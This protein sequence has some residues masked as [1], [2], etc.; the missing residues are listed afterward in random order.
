MVKPEE[1][2]NVN[3]T[4]HFR[5]SGA[6]VLYRG[7]FV[8][9]VGPTSDGTK[10]GV[11]RL[12]GHKEKDE[13]AIVTAKREAMEEASV[14]ITPISSS[15]TFYVKEWN[16]KPIK[17]EIKEEIAPIL[18]K[19]SEETASIMYLSYSKTKPLPS[20]ETK[21][22]LFLS[23][24]DVHLVCSNKLTL[25]DFL[26]QNG[27]SIIQSVIDRDLILEPFPQLLFL[28]KLL[29]EEKELMYEYIRRQYH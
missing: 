13:S 11:V 1:G 25:N 8:F 17:L 3:I 4:K 22:L 10:L 6:Y 28:S 16:D 23:P 14:N 24:N 20:A 27:S 21:G 26:K 7:Y 19:G 9:Q 29:L 5:T 18:I 15:S 2:E 12:G